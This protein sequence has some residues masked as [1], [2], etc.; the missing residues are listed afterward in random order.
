VAQWSK[1]SAVTALRNDLVDVLADHGG[2][3]TAT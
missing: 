1:L 3:M 2:V